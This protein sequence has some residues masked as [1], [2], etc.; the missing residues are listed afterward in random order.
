MWNFLS[1]WRQLAVSQRLTLRSPVARSPEQ[2]RERAECRL[3][4]RLSDFV[5]PSDFELRISDFL[6]SWLLALGSWFLVLGS[7]FLALGFSALRSGIA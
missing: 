1:A 4:F 2:A 3:E 5:L 6:D 7:W